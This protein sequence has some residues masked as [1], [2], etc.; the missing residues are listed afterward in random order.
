MKLSLSLLVIMLPHVLNAQ[1]PNRIVQLTKQQ[2]LSQPTTSF[3]PLERTPSGK[4]NHIK[5][6]LYPSLR[7][8]TLLEAANYQND[9]HQI[10]TK[11][12]IEFTIPHAESE[13]IL[14]LT[15]N[16][17]TTN[18]FTVNTSSGKKIHN[19]PSAENHYMG[20][21]KG[22]E[23]SLAGFSL[24]KTGIQGMFTSKKGQYFI[25]NVRGQPGLQNLYQHE[26]LLIQPPG[27]RCATDDKQYEA[28]L[29]NLKFNPQK[30]PD[31][32][33]TVRMYL[34]ASYALY[35]GLGSNADAVVDYLLDMFN[36]ANIFYK[37]EGIHLEVSEIFIWDR[38]D[39]YQ[40]VTGIT[41]YLN[42]FH[43]RLLE[44]RRSGNHMK[45]DIAHSMTGTPISNAAARGDIRLACQAN[46]ICVAASVAIGLYDPY[47]TYSFTIYIFSHETGHQL[48]AP[49]SHSC[50]WPG[51]PMDNCAQQEG[52]CSPGPP[53]PAAGGTIMS[54][55]P[56][57]DFLAGL[58]VHPP[59]LMRSIIDTVSCLQVCGQPACENMPVHGFSALLT[60]TSMLIKWTKNSPKYR[61]GIKPNTTRKWI[62]YEVT[63]ADSLKIK[64]N[65]C[66]KFFEYSIAPFCTVENKYGTNIIRSAGDHAALTL[67]FTGNPNP[68]MCPGDSILLRILPAPAGMTYQW[69]IGQNILPYANSAIV[70]VGT[71]GNFV[72]KGTL[73]G[74]VYHSDTMPVTF[75]RTPPIVTGV[76]DGRKIT[77]FSN[78]NCGR[79]FLWDLG[80]GKTDTARNP[81]H[82]Y[83]QPG[84]YPVKLS[85]WDFHGVKD[86]AAGEVV[87]AEELTDNLEPPTEWTYP[88]Y[89]AIVNNFH[90]QYA[91][92]FPK[93]ASE[94]YYP[95]LVYLSTKPSTILSLPR[96]GT[97]EIK[98][99]PVNPYQKIGTN[100]STV[101]DTG[102]ILKG[103]NTNRPLV[104]E[105][106]K[107]G[108]VMLTV[109][110]FKVGSLAPE[111]AGK[112][113]LNQWN[114]IGLS[115]GDLGIELL[116][117]GTSNGKLDTANVIRFTETGFRVGFGSWNLPV[118]FIP[119]IYGFEGGI[120][121]IRMSETEKDYTF[122]SKPT[123]QG[124]DTSVTL[125]TICAGATYEGQSNAGIYYK[126]LKNPAGCD[127]VI[128]T[129]LMVA[130]PLNIEGTV[131][132]TN[133]SGGSIHSSVAGGT[134]GFSYQWSNGGSQS[135]ITGQ[136]AGMYQL[137]VT[138]SLKCTATKNF[139]IYKTNGLT[140]EYF[141]ILPNPVKEMEKLILQIYSVHGG[142][143]V[144]NIFD[145]P[146]RLINSRKV[147]LAPGLN[148][149][150]YDHQLRAG[151]YV[152]EIESNATRFRPLKL[153]V[154]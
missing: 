42:N 87:I 117:N 86:T 88:V 20:F 63:T 149:I 89:S 34:E 107:A 103:Q 78:T 97:L 131:T 137:T 60:D 15:K 66:D 54:Y 118:S 73:N 128:T 29:N 45:A 94:F 25:D 144:V 136:P 23:N 72:V 110:S 100:P 152:V 95:Y 7:K 122:S 50:S 71:S 17:I 57:I 12:N 151:I 47:P 133:Q 19:H 101:P 33:K 84:R 32:C 51:G 130:K 28:N 26:D 108:A 92:Y 126:T 24:A 145:M 129:H 119:N 82:T 56:K 58:G 90:C 5:T 46:S 69:Y 141:R 106:T 4:Y 105:F 30:D 132:S 52:T 102:Y 62:Y 148:H 43:T 76:S 8:F 113:K 67:K 16:K 96:K 77:L 40:G 70:R 115:F 80:D 14:Q 79:K 61:I 31:N 6:A 18:D 134:G 2:Y 36:N 109:D 93:D 49:H 22:D 37:N 111:S 150:N 139:I 3:K 91:I 83:S 68:Q 120:A 112:L 140:N 124:T 44:E 143:F 53:M 154:R 142:E 9:R 75:R 11:Q 114:T 27:I 81:I 48:G 121:K 85:S 35:S 38:P 153:Q 21:V 13:T 74:C 138:D 104:L 1:Q 10:T 127:S 41:T 98:I 64:I 39:N 59:A 65:T 146:G 99:F 116:V 135:F 125:K 55:C 123:W 147:Q